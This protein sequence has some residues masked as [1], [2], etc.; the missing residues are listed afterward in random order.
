MGHIVASAGEAPG[1][2]TAWI[3]HARLEEVRAKNP[4]LA[5]RRFG[6]NVL[7]ADG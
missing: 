7:G 2:V 3:D 6:V 4:S 5:N 1:F